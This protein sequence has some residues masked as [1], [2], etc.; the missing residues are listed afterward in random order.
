MWDSLLALSLPERIGFFLPSRV[1]C[2]ETVIRWRQC[3]GFSELAF[4][5]ET[6]LSAA[7]L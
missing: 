7:K 3:V 4:D 2:G 6:E 5:A 1:S